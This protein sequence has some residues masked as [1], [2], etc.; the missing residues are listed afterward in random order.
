MFFINDFINVQIK[1]NVPKFFVVLFSFR[2][3]AF[4]SHHDEAFFDKR[5]KHT[6]IIKFMAQIYAKWGFYTSVLYI[7]TLYKSVEFR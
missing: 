6:K 3:L 7:T 2:L 4:R 5:H 1:K